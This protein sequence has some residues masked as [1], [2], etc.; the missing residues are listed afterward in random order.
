MIE[1]QWD[2]LNRAGEGDSESAINLIRGYVERRRSPIP[3]EVIRADLDPA[4]RSNPQDDRIWLGEANLAIRV[5]SYEEA[6]RWLDACLRRRPEDPPV[7]RSRLNWAVATN[8]VPEALEA[9]KHLPVRESPPAQVWRLAAWLAARRGDRDSER[10]AWEQLILVDPTDSAA[11]DR[12]DELAV[13]EGQPA[14]SDEIRRR[15]AEIDRLEARYDKLYRRNQPT[16]DAEEMAHLAD[17][18]GRRFEARAFLTV[19]IM[20]DPDRDD[21]RRDLDRLNRGART[22]EEPSRTIADVLSADLDASG[23]HSPSAAIRPAPRAHF[24]ATIPPSGAPG[25]TERKS[26]LE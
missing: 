1:A 26:D 13:Q 14:R 16:R 24:S 17:Q 18:L 11:F 8:R 21:L 20:T 10:R 22:V 4:A 25:R 9:I 12:L 23:G 2:T 15:K 6:A 7:W 5:G 19:A 3:V